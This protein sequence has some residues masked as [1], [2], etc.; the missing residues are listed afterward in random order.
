MLTR[1][2]S[3]ETRNYTQ[4]LGTV[5]FRSVSANLPL[6]VLVQYLMN[7]QPLVTNLRRHMPFCTGVGMSSS[8]RW[9]APELPTAAAP[10]SHSQTHLSNSLG[11]KVLQST[12][13]TRKSSTKQQKTQ[14]N[15]SVLL[16]GKHSP[17]SSV[18]APRTL[19]Y[20]PTPRSLIPA[21]LNT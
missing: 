17:V 16:R 20:L 11:V 5:T 19:L 8:C 12:E 4:Q 14:D 15:V 1:T 9:F 3:A 18:R 21:T 6:S 13:N 10:P 7:Q 2:Y